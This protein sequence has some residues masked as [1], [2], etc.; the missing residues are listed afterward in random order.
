MQGCSCHHGLHGYCSIERCILDNQLGC[1]VL[2]AI[3]ASCSNISE[4]GRSGLGAALLL[5]F[6]NLRG[7][8][9]SQ[10]CKRMMNV[11]C[12]KYSLFT[13]SPICSHRR[14]RHYPDHLHHP[15][16]RRRHHHH[17]HRQHP[18][19]NNSPSLPS[20]RTLILESFTSSRR[21]CS[22]AILSTIFSEASSFR[23][24]LGSS[25]GGLGQALRL[26]AL[27]LT[28]YGPGGFLAMPQ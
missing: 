16:H 2:E 13:V 9:R 4:D 3:A 11:F 10:V 6:A 22:P 20:S 8:T 5:Q 23:S 15:H 17:H 7:S 25:S 24:A 28:R 27:P 26:V 21:F 14:H 12:L 19:P 18:D 1:F